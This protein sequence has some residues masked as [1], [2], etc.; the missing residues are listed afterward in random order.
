[1]TDSTANDTL[2]P[3][4]APFSMDGFWIGFRRAY[5]TTPGIVLFGMGFGAAAAVKGLTFLDAFFFQSLVLAGASQ[6]VALELWTDP[7]TWTTAFAMGA[8]VF[9]VNLR[10]ML[11]GAALRPWMGGLPWYKSYPSLAIMTDPAWIIA[12]RYH[13]E[14]GQDWGVYVGAC[15]F[16][17]LMWIVSVVPGYY[18][19]AAL[20]NP[21]RYG[22]DL[23]MP[24]FFITMLVP[25]WRGRMDALPWGLAIVVAL[26]VKALVPGFWFIVAGGLA[27][28]FLAAALYKDEPA[29]G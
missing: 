21:E 18:L 11:L 10:M 26:V 4:P 2:V 24:L 16:L 7:L 19:S 29:D 17:Y 25:V 22:V 20:E 23:I 14:G 6:Y 5:V 27:A 13:R 8:V 15:V 9:T 1:M 28:A 12:I 3:G